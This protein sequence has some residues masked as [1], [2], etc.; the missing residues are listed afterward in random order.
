MSVQQYVKIF[1]EFARD[2]F[3]I[4]FRKHFER[5][6]TYANADTARFDLLR[7]IYYRLL[8]YNDTTVVRSK[9]GTS[10]GTVE[11]GDSD[12]DAPN[13]IDKCAV[14]IASERFVWMF[15]PCLECV[16]PF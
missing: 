2:G 10:P 1:S 4:P 13:F 8:T 11:S 15:M 3:G 6:M 9:I 7:R 14:V 12:F 16:K 5:V